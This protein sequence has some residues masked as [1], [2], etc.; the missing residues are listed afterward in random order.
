MRYLLAIALFTLGPVAPAQT[1]TLPYDSALAAYAAGDHQRALDGFM[2]LAATRESATLY[3]N[4]GNCHYKLGDV[5]RAVLFYERAALLAP[6]DEDI[7][8]NLDLSRTLVVDRV[9]ELPGFS[10]GTTWDRFRS[11]G[12]PDRWAVLSLWT[13]LGFFAALA[14]TILLSA[15]W[16][17]RLSAVLAVVMLVVAIICLSFAAQRHSEMT[18]HD[19]AIILAPKVDVL[20]EPKKDGTLLFLLHEGTKVKVL[21]Q[22]GEWC[23]V[24]LSNGS[25]GW[26]PA[27]DLE[28]I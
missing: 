8:T 20:S 9:N 12:A 16:P 19:Q 10:L 3:F 15:T 24:K 7:R 17:R 14:A 5:A 2:A 28:R 21:E 11:G 25:V 27:A 23:S 26:M 22:R 13:C 1:T 4:I 6:G 18:A